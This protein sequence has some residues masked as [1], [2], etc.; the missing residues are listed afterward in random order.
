M[1]SCASCDGRN[2]ISL[3]LLTGFV[4]IF[5]FIQLAAEF[6]LSL[7]NINKFLDQLAQGNKAPRGKTEKALEAKMGGCKDNFTSMFSITN[8]PLLRETGRNRSTKFFARR[9]AYIR[10]RRVTCACTTASF[11]FSRRKVFAAFF[12][13]LHSSAEHS[14]DEEDVGDGTSKV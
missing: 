6:E 12:E 1:A 8:P 14:N 11:C 13:R 7:L 10:R 3:S 9:S 4:K 2:N 5:A